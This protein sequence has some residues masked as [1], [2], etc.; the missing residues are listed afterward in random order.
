MANHRYYKYIFLN[1]CLLACLS[2][3]PNAHAQHFKGVE[4]D[5]NPVK[6][7]LENLLKSVQEDTNKVIIL[8]LLSYEC[9]QVEYE[10]ALEHGQAALD[11]ANKLNYVSGIASSY[12]TIAGAYYFYG[13]YKLAVEW[14]QKA[15]ALID[16][17]DKLELARI[18]QNLGNS[19]SGNGNYFEA[20]EYYFKA[21]SLYQELGDTAG[22]VASL[23][24]IGVIYFSRK[25]FPEALKYYF[26]MLEITEGTVHEFSAEDAFNNIATVYIEMKDYELALE[27]FDKALKMYKKSDSEW[28]TAYTFQGMGEV[29]LKLGDYASSIEYLTIS[30]EICEKYN[31]NYL[32]IYCYETIGRA[33]ALQGSL[34]AG[35]AYQNN[36]MDLATE[37]ELPDNILEVHKGL[38][39]TYELMGKAELSLYHYKRYSAIGDSLLNAENSRQLNEMAAKYDTDKKEKEL[40]NLKKQKEIDA[41][42]REAESSRQQLMTI[43]S[44]VAL[45]LVGII[46]I[47]MY[48]R[49]RLKK[50]AMALLSA[51]NTLITESINYAKRIQTAILPPDELIK[52]H[53]PDSFVLFKPKDIVSGD[54][55]WSAIKGDIGMISAIDCTG[56]GVPGAF[57]SMIGNQLLTEIVNEKGITKPSEVLK[58]LHAGVIRSLHQKDSKSSR[59]GMDI[60]FCTINHKTLEL[61]FAGAHNPFYL[62]RNGELREIKGDRLFIGDERFGDDYTNHVIQL[63]KGDVYYLASDGFADQ[64]GGLKGQKFYSS[65]F[66]ELLIEIHKEDMSEQKEHLDKVIIEWMG[67]GSQVDDILVI[68]VRV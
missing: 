47:I 20:L 38:S 5:Y 15:L 45:I 58:Q 59:D 37:L 24:N 23:Q 50:K 62:I 54:F 53:L 68:G 10:N 26:K 43:F 22:A 42:E 32:L 63:K 55:Y 31:D 46:G 65:R 14:H 8:N 13:R 33:L 7:S 66:K 51:K 61:Q 57:M 35:L 29:Y 11:L 21:E 30:L 1:I 41:I 34:T 52:K 4:E 56:H 9:R 27:Y 49:Y 19:I 17:N 25:S 44:I 18:Y 6:D 39:E 64:F 36:A 40:A 3:G 2:A 28:G 16:P 67:K 12:E 48:N 60:A